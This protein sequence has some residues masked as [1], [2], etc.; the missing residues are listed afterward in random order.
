MTAGPRFLSV[1]FITILSLHLSCCR[2]DFC[3]G[4]R[5]SRLRFLFFD[6]S[7]LCCSFNIFSKEEILSSMCKG[8]GG[9]CQLVF[10]T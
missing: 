9:G 1:G 3:K 10:L 4:V 7:V 6:R 5:F 8:A 2:T